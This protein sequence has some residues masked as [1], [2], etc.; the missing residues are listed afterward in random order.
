VSERLG[1]KGEMKCG[2][3]SGEC[4]GVGKV[5]WC[6]GS[7]SRRQWNFECLVRSPESLHPGDLLTLIW[8]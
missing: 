6:N 2:E 3:S 1:G 4:Q 8:F 7:E 5:L